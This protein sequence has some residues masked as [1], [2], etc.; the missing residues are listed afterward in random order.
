MAV[1]LV[2]GMMMLGGAARADLCGVAFSDGEERRYY[3]VSTDDASTTLLSVGPDNLNLGL[4]D[5]ALGTDGELYGVHGIG[6]DRLDPIAGGFECVAEI[7]GSRVSRRSFE[8]S[9]RA[10]ECVPEPYTPWGPSAM[11]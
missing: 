1:R 10:S 7:G 4:H 5:I 2:A 8:M 6:I 3:R 11:P 9:R